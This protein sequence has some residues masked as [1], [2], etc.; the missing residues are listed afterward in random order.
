VNRPEAFSLA[1]KAALV[2]GS[3]RGIGA[4]IA[5]LFAAHGAA[6][7][8]TA[9]TRVDVDAVVA[10]IVAAGGVAHAACADLAEPGAAAVL[11][12]AA[13]ARFGRLD[14]LVHN[15]GI[16]PY[17]P[18]ESMPDEAWQ[19]VLDLNLG[20]ALRLMR[21]GLPHLKSRGGRILFTSSI[22]GNRA[23]IR[24]CAHYAA[25]KGGLNGLIRAAALELAPCGITVNG[26]E[27]GLVLT[28]EVARALTPERRERMA[29]GVPL[30]RWGLPEE[31]AHAMLFLA[32]DAAAYVT[33]QTLV[34][35]GGATLPVFGG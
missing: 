7:L 23:A 20:A 2:T 14:I 8:V 3:G 21:A 5:R 17:H 32:S 10:S 30:G 9:R 18:I 15:A 24:G 29:R 33:G 11:V 27:P 34:V 6:V 26:V 13:V 31:T 19:H 22:Q 4:A 25:S 16:Y 28:G 12:D 35:D 1:G